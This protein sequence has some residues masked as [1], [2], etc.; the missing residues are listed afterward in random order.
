MRVVPAVAGIAIGRQRDLGDIP[1]HVARLTIEAAVRPGQPVSRLR[2]VIE[3]PPRPTVRIVAEPAVRRETTLMMLVPVTGNARPRGIFERQRPM[4]FLTG[5]DGVATDQRKSRDV[6][7]ERDYATPPRLAVA[8]LA[9][10]AELT[11]VPVILAMTGGTGRCQLV[12]IEIAR[13]AVIAFDLGMRASQRELRRLAMIETE[14]APF[15][16]VVAALALGAVPPA[17]DVLNS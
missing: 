15:A 16:F 11:L 6:M 9:P 17:M 2:V 3:A 12:A 13:V 10:G 14:R 1:G 4:A 7:V 8:L 5:H